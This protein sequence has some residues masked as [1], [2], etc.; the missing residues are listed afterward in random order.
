[1]PDWTVL[2]VEVMAIVGAVAVF[3]YLR[4][5]IHNRRTDRRRRYQRR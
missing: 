3:E 5:G 1:M 4:M 2:F